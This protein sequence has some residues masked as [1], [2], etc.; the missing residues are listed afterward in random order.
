MQA[1][2][3]TSQ[4]PFTQEDISSIYGATLPEDNLVHVFTF[5]EDEERDNLYQFRFRP[6]TR[7]IERADRVHWAPF[8]DLIKKM[9]KCVKNTQDQTIRQQ[10]SL[11]LEELIE[12]DSTPNSCLHKKKRFVEAFNSVPLNYLLPFP[13]GGPIIKAVLEGKL[14]NMEL[15]LDRPVVGLERRTFE[16]V[17]REVQMPQIDLREL[18]PPPQTYIHVED[19]LPRLTGP[20]FGDLKALLKKTTSSPNPPSSCTIL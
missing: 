5:L 19:C 10:L 13:E 1:T 12:I 17:F 2:S 9:A 11:C 3:S 15:K 6:L 7:L 20:D 16:P 8:K 14:G 18:P 4:A